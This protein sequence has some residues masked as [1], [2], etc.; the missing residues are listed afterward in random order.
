MQVL[1]LRTEYLEN[2]M[3]IHESAPQLSWQLHAQQRGCRQVAWHVRV[4]T[5]LQL[6]GSEPDL[7]DSRKVESNQTRVIYGGKPL[8][9]RQQ[10]YWQ[11][12][13]WDEHDKPTPWSKPASWE[14]GLLMPE[15]WR[16]KWIGMDEQHR[17]QAAPLLRHTFAVSQTP[18]QARLYI[19]GLG[20]YEASLN[21]KRIGEQVLD[22]GQTDYQKRCFYA[23]HDVIDLITTGLNA[24]GVMLG[25][26]WYN[27]NI[28]W[29]EQKL[30]YGPPRLL[31]QLELRFPNDDPQIIASD[32]DWRVHR[33][34]V[35]KNNIYAG[36]T[37]DARCQQHGWDTHKFDD[38]HWDSP[39]TMPA[40]GGSL[41]AQLNPPIRKC[42]TITPQNITSP[43]DGTWMLDMGENFA[44]WVR[45]HLHKPAAGTTIT[46][47]FAETVHPDGTLDPASTGVF[48]TK[49]V[50]TDTYICEGVEEEIWEPR[51]TYHGF[52]Y[53]EIT[54]LSAEPNPN[55][56]VGVVVHTDLISA[57]DFE[58][59]DA[60]LNLL[61]DMAK[62]THLANVHSVPTDCPARERCGWLGDAIFVSEYSL[63]NFDSVAFWRKYLGDIETTRDGGMPYD[64]APGRRRCARG[65]ADWCVAQILIPWYVYLH[66]ADERILFNAWDG[67]Q[68]VINDFAGRADSWILSGGRGDWCDPSVD[69]KPAYTPETLTT[70][71]WFYVAANIMAHAARKLKKENDAVRYHHWMQKIHGAFIKHYFDPQHNSF[72]SQT[73]NAMALYFDLI[74]EGKR[75]TI[76][77][78]LVKDI[79]EQHDYHWTT[80]IMGLRYLGDAL[81]DNGYGKVALRLF[82]QISP[83]SFGDLIRRGATT[84]WEYW[85]ETEVDQAEGPRSLSHPMFGGFD[86][87]FFQG[88]AGICPDPQHPG[89][90]HVLLKPQFIEGLEYAKTTYHSLQGTIESHWQRE[91]NNLTW[92]VTLPANTSATAVVALPEGLELLESNRPIKTT[93]NIQILNRNHG[94]ATLRIASGQYNFSLCNGPAAC[95]R[96]ERP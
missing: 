22:P 76:A 77:D 73:A 49:V 18:V 72:G 64:I 60:M 79:V 43:K 24:L 78:A 19:C 61:H 14:M 55:D 8:T 92:D 16:A 62:R 1:T 4:A 2:P 50:Q 56:F 54:G 42:R 45:L 12:R 83:P 28:V 23:V 38:A 88:I 59:S 51:F 93:P 87:W 13:A 75:D 95:A 70:T 84:L 30:S 20:Y 3:G 35:V 82:N 29:T 81:A 5:T 58:C 33:G 57:G 10:C 36:E 37:Y 6:L 7:W 74:P 31:A 96:P 34:P 26:G 71:I 53:V 66:T 86:T 41:T 94:Q 85:G 69:T 25:D 52:R 91:Q 40:P 21:G 90:R 46:M 68:V 27:Q 32:H 47:R 11:V 48:A 17:Q 80:G 89:F 9:S 44:G 67:M 15:D 63:Y 65:I 39:V